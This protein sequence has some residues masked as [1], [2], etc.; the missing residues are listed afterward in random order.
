M[1]ELII[2][3]GGAREVQ[4]LHANAYP[5]EIYRPMCEGLDNYKISLPYQRHLWEGSDPA[6]MR[7]WSILIDDLIEHMDQ[8][9]KKNVIGMGHSMGGI[10]SMLVAI[11]R[12]DLFSQLIL[13]DPVILPTKFV[14][15][16]KYIPYW[17]KKRV[18]PIVKIASN[19]REQWASREEVDKH[20]GSKKIFQRWDNTAWQEFLKYGVVDNDQ[21]VTLS[22]PRAWE[23]KVYGTAPDVWSQLPKV[24]VPTTIIKAQYSDVI[25]SDSW[26]TIKSRMP[27]HVHV[28]MEGVGHLVPFEK[29]AALAALIKT[30][31]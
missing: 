1:R 22:F 11:K 26:N 24:N 14:R 29:P 25:T 9:G 18:V 5:P 28:E 19:R 13:I 30:Y 31:L 20:L 4:M 27:G 15:Y 12:P 6:E 23:A 2:D 16:N 21:G 8:R 17:L 10:I 7:N 3:N